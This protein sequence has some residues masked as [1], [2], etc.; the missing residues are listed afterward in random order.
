M[1]VKN[2]VGQ[3][4]APAP[5]SVAAAPGYH[6]AAVHAQSQ[7]QTFLAAAGLADEAGEN[8]VVLHA[9]ERSGQSPGT[10]WSH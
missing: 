5:D 3:T 1:A 4:G 8:L 7:I 6:A 9:D 10:A 2:T